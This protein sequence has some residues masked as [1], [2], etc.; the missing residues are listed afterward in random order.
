MCTRALLG[1]GLV[2]AR[3][4]AMIH[5]MLGSHPN[6]VTYLQG[7]YTKNVCAIV[8]EHCEYDS[9]YSMIC[10]RRGEVSLIGCAP[11]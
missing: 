4:Q 5:K 6:I 10:S 7:Y 11:S 2:R 3:W 8:M 9:L 1:L